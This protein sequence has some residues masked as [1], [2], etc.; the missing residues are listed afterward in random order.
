MS[1][2]RATL[3]G[4]RNGCRSFRASQ[5]REIENHLKAMR[6]AAPETFRKAG[7]AYAVP[8]LD[9]LFDGVRDMV[10]DGKDEARIDLVDTVA[11]DLAAETAAN[12]ATS[13]ACYATDMGVRAEPAWRWHDRDRRS[14]VVA[15]IARL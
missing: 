1:I 3:V 14:G 9:R 12:I 8:Y 7:M 11:D 5:I 2:L 15:L 6:E 10:L 13:F 4:M